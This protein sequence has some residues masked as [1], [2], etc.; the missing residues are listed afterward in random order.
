MRGEECD[1]IVL[2]EATYKAVAIARRLGDV[3]EGDTCKGYRYMG[4][5]RVRF[6]NVEWASRWPDVPAE[7]RQHR[8]AFVP[9]QLVLT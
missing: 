5:Q 9:G 2:A 1:A 3:I 8:R 6:V 4:Y 7:D